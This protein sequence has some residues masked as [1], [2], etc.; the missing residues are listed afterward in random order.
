MGINNE[1][2]I[3]VILIFFRFKFNRFIHMNCLST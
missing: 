1:S 2:I 3:V